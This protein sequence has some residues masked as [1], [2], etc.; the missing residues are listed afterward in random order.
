MRKAILLPLVGVVVLG[1]AGAGAYVV[2]SRDHLRL[3]TAALQQGDLRRAQIELRTAVR[4]S[5]TSGAAHYELAVAEARLGDPFAAEKDARAALSAGYDEI[6]A[7]PVLAQ[8]YL[9]QTHFRELL[10]DFPVPAGPPEFAA[11]IGMLRAVALLRLGDAPAARTQIDAA[12]K[13]APNMEDVVITSAQ[14]ALA[15]RDA[16]AAGRDI[17]RALA[18]NPKSG[19]ALFLRSELQLAAGDR[20]GARTTLDAA[21]AASP[22]MSAA[23]LSRANLLM[24]ANGD[25]AAKSDVDQ[26]VAD[27]PRNG[28]GLY[29]RAVLLTRA[30][31]WRGADTVFTQ[32]API[33]NRFPRGLYFAAIVKSNLG[34][35]EQATDMAARYVAR[36][37]DDLDGVKTLARIAMAS[38]HVDQALAVLTKAA[39]SGK[40]D[41][42]TLDLLGRA[43]T[44]SGQPGEAV[45]TFQ[46]ASS[47][48]PNNAD[49]LTHL[50]STRLGMGD[51]G[52]AAT[53]FERSLQLAPKSAET[54]ES[55]VVAALSAGD[56]ARAQ[57]ALQKLRDSTGDTVVVG[58]LAGLIKLSQVDL[59]GARA[60][61][62]SVLKAHPDA[63]PVQLNLAKV[64]FLQGRTGDA[65]ALL[66]GVLQVQPTNEAAL[67][68]MINALLSTGRV[69]R[70]VTVL[71]KAHDAAPGDAGLASA[72]SDLDVRA[73]DAQKALTLLDGLPKDQVT[74]PVVLG[75]RARAQ[76]ALNQS[77]D[78]RETYR[79]ILAGN[80]GDLD[81]RARLAE[82][83]VVGG[84]FPAART[85]VQDGLKLSPKNFGMLTALVRIDQRASGIEA[86]VATAER[87]ERDPANLPDA[88]LLKGDAYM[89]V[90]QFDKAASAFTA[91]MKASPSTIMATRVALAQIALGQP[92]AAM[93]TLS[94]WVAKNPDD[95]TA[96]EPLAALELQ[97]NR[98][99]L[100]EKHF[101]TVV[102]KKPN[103]AQALNNLAWL[104]QLRKDPRARDLAQRAYALVPAPEMADTL[105]W[106]LTNDGQVT[107]GL[108]LLRLASQRL[109]SNL[110][111]QY[112]YGV[113][114]R[115]AG[116]RDEAV[117]VLTVAVSGADFS[118]K[119]A[120]QQA[121]REL[122]G[123]K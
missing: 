83:L 18:I 100:A 94:G 102:E 120:A 117:R 79:R 97:L 81:A 70:A 76:V 114:L 47:L 66:D 31:D 30:K 62:E 46:K 73:G 6:A 45:T 20:A 9:D 54:G 32:L 119:A 78:A 63:I 42:D 29:L 11:R 10:S 7:R 90:R 17:D 34:Q 1:A 91:E 61:F 14:I 33:L 95:L 118:D 24:G 92:D 55:L 99:D 53:D 104:Y 122:N 40:A 36:T 56:I 51:A 109:G 25:A 65:E 123:Q 50:A 27:E 19:S 49:I 39:A 43:Y 86:A 107:T 105:G 89:A 48:A 57:A 112:H 41:A 106:I 12:V 2:R 13:A 16:A 38:K 5:P 3:G 77:S 84:D 15:S 98:S 103:D 28:L 68:S 80:P 35:L 64:N 72:L 4:N 44:L 116:Q 23:R 82:L 113:A 93:Q 87:L 58:N 115:D 8:A 59:D 101:Q 88:T 85:L 52:G 111:V 21:I 74:L 67:S 69:G 121:L 22:H 26:V 60:Q 75:A 108:P 37:P 110:A 71:Q 96:L